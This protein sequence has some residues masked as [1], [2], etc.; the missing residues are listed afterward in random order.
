MQLLTKVISDAD[1]ARGGEAHTNIADWQLELHKFSWQ[2]QYP[3]VLSSSV[4]E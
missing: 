2:R 4:K 3:A 1:I